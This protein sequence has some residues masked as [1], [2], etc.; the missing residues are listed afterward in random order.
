MW[1]T[2]FRQTEKAHDDSWY[3]DTEE[4]FMKEYINRHYHESVLSVLEDFRRD[5]TYSCSDP[6]MHIKERVSVTK[7]S[8]TAAERHKEDFEN[9]HE[10]IDV[11]L[12][13]Y[14]CIPCCVILQ[15]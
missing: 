3:Q 15:L 12:S 5:A 10:D 8:N 4:N 1:H 13:T 6:R 11:Y 2:Q 14:G 9:L 7:L